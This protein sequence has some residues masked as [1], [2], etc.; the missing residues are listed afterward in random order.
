MIS[1][2]L[3]VG[4]GG[5]VG[6]MGRYLIGV[7]AQRWWPGLFPWGTLIANVLG[8]LLIGLFFGLFSRQL[9]SDS[10]KLLLMTGFCGGFTT[11]S[12]FA[13]ENL[14]LYQKGEY[15]T[16]TIYLAVSILAGIGAVALGLSLSRN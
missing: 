11:F 14:T 8:A 12:T 7:Y 13:H 10:Q 4:V 5:A 16:L 1:N 15:G 3:W 6:S 9:L 2:L